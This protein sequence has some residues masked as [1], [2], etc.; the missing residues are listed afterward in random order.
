MKKLIIITLFT[1]II[2]SCTLSNKDDNTTPETDSGAI[3]NVDNTDSGTVTGT[4]EMSEEGKYTIDDNT[5]TE[6]KVETNSGGQNVSVEK[7]I[8][9]IVETNAETSKDN[10]TE[11]EILN[12]I[13]SLINDII[14][15]AENG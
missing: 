2:S 6:V 8:E 12:D 5:G 13:D 14:N 3:I 7:N 1:L 11:E 10:V 15:S 9:T 4:G